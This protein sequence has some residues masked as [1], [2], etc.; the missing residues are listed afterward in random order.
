MNRF[1][2]ISHHINMK[3][4]KKKHLEEIAARKIE[5]IRIE[6]ERKLHNE[7]YD[8]WKS[9]WRDELE[10]K[11]GM[12]V[13]GSFLTTVPAEG[14]T[15]LSSVDVNNAN[16][17]INTITSSEGDSFLDPSGSSYNQGVGLF[18]NGDGFGPNGGFNFG[19][20]YIGFGFPYTQSSP[21]FGRAEIKAQDLS[22]I[23]SI[24]ANVIRG[25]DSNGGQPP[26]EVENGGL[27]IQ[28]KIDGMDTF[29]ELNVKPDGTTD[30]SVSNILI[31]GFGEGG[32]A[33]DTPNNVI[34]TIPEYVRTKTTQLKLITTGVGF[35]IAPVYGVNNF[36]FQR[37]APINVFVSLDSPEAT[38]FVRLGTR[39][40]DPKKRRKNV[41]DIL[42]A[43]QKYTNNQFDT[44]FPGSTTTLYDPEASPIGFDQFKTQM[45]KQLMKDADPGEFEKL[46]QDLIND[47]EVFNDPEGA[48]QIK[49]DALM[50][51]R[52]G[53]GPA[54]V[55]TYKASDFTPGK[56][57][58][59]GYS[60][61]ELEKLSALDPQKFSRYKHIR[62]IHD[63]MVN[64]SKLK[65]EKI[66]QEYSNQ[67]RPKLSSLLPSNQYSDLY[68]EHEGRAFEEIDMELDRLYDEEQKAMT[69]VKTKYGV[70][71]FANEKS[72]AIRATADEISD[73]R[74]ILQELQNKLW[75]ERFEKM[76]ALTAED[77]R[78]SKALKK[79]APDMFS[80]DTGEFK[81]LPMYMGLKSSDPYGLIYDLE[82][83]LSQTKPITKPMTGNDINNLDNQQIN[84]AVKDV[85]SSFGPNIGTGFRIFGDFLTKGHNER[86]VADR[87]YL[88]KEYMNRQ[89]FPNISFDRSATYVYK[90]VVVGSGQPAKYNEKTG[91]IE[92]RAIFDFKTNAQEVA[93]AIASEKGEKADWA[94]RFNRTGSKY[95]LDAIVDP[96]PGVL[97]PLSGMVASHLISTA[98][99][100]GKGNLIP[101]VIKFTPEELKLKNKKAY[102]ELVELD[103]I[104]KD[105]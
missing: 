64:K 60:P 47:Q 90:D 62:D 41:E 80:P 17:Y 69:R 98:K 12:T 10:L 97:K 7:I 87:K 105:K 91:M 100:L 26:L 58:A 66:N 103:T 76:N 95:A 35:H 72:R 29:K 74:P 96:L 14:D 37:R 81:P 31:P 6:E 38:S 84:T 24:V 51:A 88:G 92:V 2:K 63:E 99:S 32:T 16:S 45:L 70:R 36:R 85:G 27:R 102:D 89:F 83:D 4:V 33:F 50:K 19:S 28:Y 11:E 43:G 54:V 15:D 55:K 40:S 49:S 22:S 77:I 73:A 59:Y 71:L 78:N 20:D 9:N 86:F 93:G 68:K 42:R 25:N 94:A 61:E 8:K 5:E 52:I 44:N 75:E 57:L 21:T 18:P 13:A 34:V 3:D 82:G 104:P 48:K 53:D 23:D 67:W 1:S 39:E 101:I 65:Q 79:F 56:G 46:Q 30:S